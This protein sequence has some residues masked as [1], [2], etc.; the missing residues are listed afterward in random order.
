MIDFVSLLSDQI[1]KFVFAP[2]LTIVIGNALK[3]L[4]QNKN[5][6]TPWRNYF[7][8]GPN[9]FSAALLISMMDIC[10]KANKYFEAG[11]KLIISRYVF[12]NVFLL[13]LVFFAAFFLMYTLLRKYGW[14]EDRF[15]YRIRWGRGVV[16]SNA[17]GF[18]V[19]YIALSILK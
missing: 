15:G 1:T 3:L 10:S 11:E 16:L 13:C 18:V 2:L 7:Y 4:C 8:W 14:E 9:A 6:I 5:M 19:L 12:N 17:I